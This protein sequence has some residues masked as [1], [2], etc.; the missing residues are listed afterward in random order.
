METPERR[1]PGQLELSDGATP[2]LETVGRIFDERAY[3]VTVSEHGGVTIAHSGNPDD[4]VADFQPRNIHGELNDGRQVSLVEAQGGA[5]PNSFMGHQYRQRFRALQAVMDERVDGAAQR[6][7]GF[8]FP[9]RGSGWWRQPDEQAQT[10]DGSWLRLTWE[11]DSRSFEF[12]PASSLTFRQVDSAVLSPITTLASLATDNPTD[13]GDLHVRLADDGPWRKVYAPEEPI[14]RTSYP[15][16]NTHL[17]ADRFAKWIDVRKRTL[18]L[19]AAAIAVLDG[20]A[21][22]AQVLTLVAGAEGLHRKL[23]DDKKRVPALEQNDVTQARRAARQAA[24]DRVRE[25]DRSGRA[26]LTDADLTEFKQ[27]I[28][29]AFSFLNER[30][31]RSRMSDLIEDAQSSIPGIAVNF[32]NWPAAVTDARN[33]LAHRGTGPGDPTGQF[34]DL[35]IALGYSIPWVLRTVLLKQA[36]FNPPALQAAYADSSRYNH[37]ITNTRYL[38]AGSPYAASENS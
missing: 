16:L 34:V 20:M 27:A 36:G 31:F 8:K 10:N 5:D 26:P 12:C 15:L 25:I 28:N 3:R 19:D 1:A 22:E 7:A 30:T 33:T 6:Y 14:G 38:L 18:G 2:V 37:H 17:T 9:V 11:D 32:S 13:V 35:L 21:I 4:L 23:F 24:L 29:D